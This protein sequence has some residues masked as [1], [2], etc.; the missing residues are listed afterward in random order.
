MVIYL[1][2]T[3]SDERI[4]KLD[5]AMFRHVASPT[6]SEDQHS[7]LAM[8]TVVRRKF[9]PFFCSEVGSHLGGSIQPHVVDSRCGST[10]SVRSLNFNRETA[11]SQN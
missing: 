5:L 4:E 2:V 3:S 7:L 1:G 8:Q 6:S 10:L 11:R 9:H